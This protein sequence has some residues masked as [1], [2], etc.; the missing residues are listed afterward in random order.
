MNAVAIA[1]DALFADSNIGTE[2]IYTDGSGSPVL[3]RVGAPLLL[4]KLLFYKDKFTRTLS[5]IPPII[6]PS[7]LA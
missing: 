1:M 2:A 7:S 5:H 3:V 4:T 6:H